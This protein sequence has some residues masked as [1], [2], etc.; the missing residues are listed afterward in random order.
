M[1]VSDFADIW[2]V[3]NLGVV[4]FLNRGSEN[5]NI[6][7]QVINSCE[8]RLFPSSGIDTVTADDD[9]TGLTPA[10][11][12]NAAGVRLDKVAGKGVYLMEY[13]KNGKRIVKKVM[14]K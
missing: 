11:V 13:H 3:K 2:N 12:Y 7:R 1:P 9:V 8:T 10:A 5:P 6:N 4:A 14:V